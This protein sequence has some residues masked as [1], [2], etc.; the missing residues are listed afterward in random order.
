MEKVDYIYKGKV[1]EVYDG[2]TITVDFDLGFFVT[3]R[4]QT[5]R[6]AEI[7]A[8]EL[9]GRERPMGLAIR[10][11]LRKKVL[12]REVVIQTIRDGKETYGRWLG[13][14]WLGSVCLNTQMQ[15]EGL[16]PKYV[17]K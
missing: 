14:V 12:G 13:Y 15:E 16:A 4:N 6:L 5:I 11:W 1:T 9:K 8:A 7:D 2:D 10:D 17:K 3:L